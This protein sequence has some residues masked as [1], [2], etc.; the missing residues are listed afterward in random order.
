MSHH[1][2]HMS[3]PMS[4][5]FHSCDHSHNICSTPGVT[6]AITMRTTRH[7]FHTIISHQLFLVE[8]GLV[9]MTPP[10][11]GFYLPEWPSS[12]PQDQEGSQCQKYAACVHG[13]PSGVDSPC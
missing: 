7:V 8:F 10:V 9:E 11:E 13:E 6:A 3:H 5:N 4:H 1:E 2:S 12:L